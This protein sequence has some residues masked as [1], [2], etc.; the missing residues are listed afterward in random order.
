MNHTRTSD[1]EETEDAKGEI[2]Q[3]NQTEHISLNAQLCYH[4]LAQFVV[5]EI[6]AIFS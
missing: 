4:A 3:R 1:V 2:S 5:F 6:P